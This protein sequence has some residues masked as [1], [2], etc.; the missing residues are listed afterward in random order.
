MIAV[1]YLFRVPHTFSTHERT[2]SLTLM[3]RTVIDS[4][5][6]TTALNIPL[7]IGKTESSPLLV[8]VVGT[9]VGCSTGSRARRSSCTR[10]Y[11]VAS[12][13]LCSFTFLSSLISGVTIVVVL[14]FGAGVKV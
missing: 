3:Y 5:G 13:L 2:L 4:V 7:R 8:A 14:S 11:C 10:I 6:L 1:L 9:T 12:V